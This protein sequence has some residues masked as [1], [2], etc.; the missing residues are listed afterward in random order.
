[1]TPFFEE[2]DWDEKENHEKV[3][4]LRRRQLFGIAPACKH[5]LEG[6]KPKRG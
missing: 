5:L 6:T 4:G 1:M 2:S 3:Q